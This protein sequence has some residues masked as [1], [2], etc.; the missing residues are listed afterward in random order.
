MV[1]F[2]LEDFYSFYTKTTWQC[3]KYM[4]FDKCAILFFQVIGIT[5]CFG[6]SFWLGVIYFIIS[7]FS[8]R[9]EPCFCTVISP[10]SYTKYWHWQPW[11]II[12]ITSATGT[13]YIPS[14]HRHITYLTCVTKLYILV[15]K[16]VAPISRKYF[17]G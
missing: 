11:Q 14:L 8:W 12:C 4:T 17:L 15:Y 9:S 6:E 16:Y 1:M 13:S 10:V 5:L 3:V 7:P 2:Q